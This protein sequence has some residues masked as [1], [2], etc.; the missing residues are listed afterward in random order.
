MS[1]LT[2]VRREV[3]EFFEAHGDDIVSSYDDGMNFPIEV[4]INELYDMFLLRMHIEKE[5][6]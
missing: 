6:E 1:S 3:D 5:F 4:T 2:D